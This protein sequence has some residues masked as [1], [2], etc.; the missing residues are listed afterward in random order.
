MFDFIISAVFLLGYA[1]IALEHH[2]NLQK[3]ITAAALGGVLWILVALAER[4]GEAADLHSL[5]GEIFGLIFFLMAAMTLV[6]ILTHYRFFEWVRA[7]LFSLQ[8]TDKYQIWVIAFLTFFLSALIDNLTTTIVMVEV[9]RRFFRGRNLLVMVS[10]IILA[11][12]AGGAWSP[13]GDVTTIMIWL[14]DK[15]QA[16]QIMA[17]GILPSLVFLFLAVKII[18]RMVVKDTPD[19]PAEQVKLA[20]SE[21][22]VI[23][24]TLGS[25][26]LPVIV[27]QLGLEPYFG[28]LAGLGFVGIL[29]VMLRVRAIKIHNISPHNLQIASQNS[30]GDNGRNGEDFLPKLRSAA[31]RTHLTADF[32]KNMSR[33]DMTS[34]LFFAGILLA[35]GALN[36]VGILDRVSVFLFGEESN[37]F[38]VIIGN[39]VLGVLS[40]I[41]DNIPLTASAIEMINID[42]PM[43]WVLLSLTVG[44]GGSLLVIGSAAGVVAM[45]R[46]KEL[47]FW[48]YLKIATWPSLVGYCGLVIFWFI[49]Y[50][51]FF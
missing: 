48:N 27:H 18:S 51:L 40:A 11:A 2:F 13:V 47:N 31:A 5:G 37:V 10:L 19:V 50:F 49:E 46:V 3:A 12:N 8:L 30:S 41:V 42:H 32:E 38:R 14:A 39:I 15:F 33:I 16:Y 20:R 26:V 29:I 9:A 24:S 23:L 1:A 43:I 6:E 7:K 17:F 22:L 35:V 21:W 36:H 25:F 44:V 4:G 28:L 34:L 45:G